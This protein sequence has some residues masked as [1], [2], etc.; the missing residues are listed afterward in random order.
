MDFNN[1]TRIRTYFL[2]GVVSILAGTLR[3]V[4]IY[5]G[6]EISIKSNSTTDDRS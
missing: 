5:A 1:D 2:L 4:F 3:H 6:G